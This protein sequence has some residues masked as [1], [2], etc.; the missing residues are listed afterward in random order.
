MREELREKVEDAIR[1]IKKAELIA[2]RMDAKLVLGFSG[3]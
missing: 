3:G 2:G 1:T